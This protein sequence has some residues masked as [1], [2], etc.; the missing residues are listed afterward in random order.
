[1]VTATK[2]MKGPDLRTPAFIPHV[3]LLC[4]GVK[5]WRNC[6]CARLFMRLT[7]AWF[8]HLLSAK[9][10]TEARRERMTLASLEPEALAHLEEGVIY[11]FVTGR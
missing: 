11:E 10:L 4:T 1:M 8:L 3:C 5:P 9:D 6:F 7:L 2:R